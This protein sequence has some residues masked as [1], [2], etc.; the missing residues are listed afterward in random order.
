MMSI[1]VLNLKRSRG[2]CFKSIKDNKFLFSILFSK[3]F[4]ILIKF[5]DMLM[6]S[7]IIVV[8]IVS[9]AV[10]TTKASQTGLQE[11]RSLELLLDPVHSFGL[12]CE[13]AASFEHIFN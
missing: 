4:V 7:V 8:I 10:T 11:L 2:G 5:L 6:V 9:M 12:C 1:W 13:S 3:Q